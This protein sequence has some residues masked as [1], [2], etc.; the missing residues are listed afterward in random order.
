MVLASIGVEIS[1][2]KLSDERHRVAVTRGDGSTDSV[3]LDTRSFLRHDLSHFAVEVEL[4]LQHGVWGAVASGG[5][6]SG[7]GLDGSDMHLAE[8][9]AGPVQTMMR[10]AADIGEIRVVLERVVPAH[11]EHAELAARLH[12][13]LR[14]LAGHWAATGYGQSMELWFP[15]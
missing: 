7:S 4:G 1:F 15:T 12:E 11:L 5:S 8:S 10:R 6:L 3:E 9:L 14:R 13:R 2:T